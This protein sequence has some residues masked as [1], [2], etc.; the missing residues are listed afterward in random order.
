MQVRAV[1][2]GLVAA[3]VAAGPGCMRTHYRDP[4]THNAH[5]GWVAA[6]TYD[7][8]RDRVAGGDV[9]VFTDLRGFGAFAHVDFQSLEQPVDGVDLRRDG[10]A[11]GFGVR[12]SPIGL[13]A[14]DRRGLRYVDVYG[15]AGV[16]AG[17]SRL[18]RGFDERLEAFVGAGFD[19]R[20]G[21]T[22]SVW[23]PALT[24]RYRRTS[25]TLDYGIADQVLIGVALVHGY[26]A[27]FSFH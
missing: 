18:P 11:F 4:R 20:L 17:L 10:G 9:E 6:V 26:S 21:F 8:G 24:A 12:V 22:S 1:A 27:R 19:L 5:D 23:F 2:A 7:A 15:D 25:S 16:A 13:L 3:A 14:E